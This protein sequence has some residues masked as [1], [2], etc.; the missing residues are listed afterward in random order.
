MAYLNV[1]VNKYEKIFSLQRKYIYSSLSSFK[2]DKTIFTLRKDDKDDDL[3]IIEISS[4][5]CDFGFK[6]TEN[7]SVNNINKLK[8]VETR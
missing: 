1:N 4:C 5:K 2:K 8:Y 7:L 6:V 3:L